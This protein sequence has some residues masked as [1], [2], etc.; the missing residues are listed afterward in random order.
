[1]KIA[2]D[3]KRLFNNPTGL[4]NYSRTIVQNFAKFFTNQNIYLC[5][6]KIKKNKLNEAF[7]QDKRYKI[8]QKL[9]KTPFWRSYFII[10]DLKKEKI[11]IYHGLSNEIPINIH[12]SGIKSIVTIHDLIFKVYPSTYKFTDRWIYDFKF[13]YACKKADVVLAISEAT[14]KDIIK[15]YKITPEKIQVVYQACQDVFYDTKE[16][17]TTQMEFENLNLPKK[18]MVYVGSVITRK[19]VIQL[20]QAFKEIPQQQKIPL[21]IVGKGSDYY[22]KCVD[23]VNQNNLKDIVIFKNNIHNNAILKLVYKHA[24]FSVYPS[25][26]E[27]FGL[28]VVESL[29]CSTPV[30]TSS[31]SSMPEAGGN[32]ALYCAPNDIS[33]LTQNMVKLIEDENLRNEL[34]KNGKEYIQTNFN[35]EK[36]SIQ[37]YSIYQNLITQN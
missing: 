10:N 33:T 19:N 5:A 28:P 37:L 21:V 35:P 13:K 4:G 22:Q 16:D 3:S 31:V 1:M 9:K 17:V 29:L 15:Y 30:I 24:L 23:F 14:K 36:L 26:Y 20:L 25:V 6:P 2:F 32:G 34:V 7:L 11:E 12:K 8:I 18:Y 27:G